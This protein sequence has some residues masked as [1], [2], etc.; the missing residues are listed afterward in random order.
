M[1]VVTASVQAINHAVDE[2]INP[3]LLFPSKVTCTADAQTRK[4]TQ[5]CQKMLSK[6]SQNDATM[7]QSDS[8]IDLEGVMGP[9]GNYIG[10]KRANNLVFGPPPRLEAQ[11]LPL[12]VTFSIWGA[13]DL[14][15]RVFFCDLFPDHVL[16]RYLVGSGA[17]LGTENRRFAL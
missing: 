14:K 10:S 1:D 11:N 8:K 5:S 12:G 16:R 17:G 2:S 13:R 9:S 15:S 6:W 3:P 7:V 4:C